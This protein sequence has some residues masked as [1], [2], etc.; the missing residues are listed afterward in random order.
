MRRR[1]ANRPFFGAH[2]RSPAQR[3]DARDWRNRLFCK[4]GRSVGGNLVF[5]ALPSELS[6]TACCLHGKMQRFEKGKRCDENFF[7][8]VIQSE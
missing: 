1:S 2:I 5:A 8:A 6:Q 7:L 4:A 3:F